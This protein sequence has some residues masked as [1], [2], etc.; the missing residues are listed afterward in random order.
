MAE[1]SRS[2]KRRGR[3]RKVGSTSCPNCATTTSGINYLSEVRPTRAT[4]LGTI[5]PALIA[6]YGV[7]RR[8]NSERLEKIWERVRHTLSEDV[9]AEAFDRV[10]IRS[11]R[12]GTLQ[13]D[14][15]D[16]IIFQEILFH[17]G[18]ILAEF[19]SEVPDERIRKIKFTVRK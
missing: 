2:G 4:K 18:R 10:E 9:A 8:M 11:F 14:V 3:R 5:V 12:G 15:P 13:F 7:G 19:Q 17:E 6:R 1:T 16:N